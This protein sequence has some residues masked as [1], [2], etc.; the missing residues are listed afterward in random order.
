MDA[1]GQEGAVHISRHG[2]MEEKLSILFFVSKR[3]LT[4]IW[5]PSIRHGS[6]LTMHRANRLLTQTLTL[7]HI[8]TLTLVC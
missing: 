2:K 4:D 8:L 6:H 7:T 1:H 3:Y 5:Y